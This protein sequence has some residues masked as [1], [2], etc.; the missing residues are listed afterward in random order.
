VVC[1]VSP[2]ATLV[3]LN[4]AFFATRDVATTTAGSQGPTGAVNSAPVPSADDIQVDEDKD[5]ESD[6]DKKDSDKDK[7]KKEKK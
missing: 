3:L 5:D 2:L 7:D 6:S 1:S 4:D